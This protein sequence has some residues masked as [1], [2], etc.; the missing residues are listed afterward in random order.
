VASVPSTIRHLATFV[1]QRLRAQVTR[2]GPSLASSLESLLAGGALSQS[3]LPLL[4][5]GLDVANGVL[6][7]DRDGALTLDW[8]KEPSDAL[9]REVVSTSRALAKNLGARFQSSTSG[10]VCTAILVC[11]SPTGR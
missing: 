4:G 2:R 1:V 8:S 5:M 9:Y 10:A 7:L 11:T 6:G 3:S